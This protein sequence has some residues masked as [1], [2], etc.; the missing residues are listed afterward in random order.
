LVASFPSS[1]TFCIAS[2]RMELNP[3]ALFELMSSGLTGSGVSGP[4]LEIGEGIVY[5]NRSIDLWIMSLTADIADTLASYPRVAA[6]KSTMSSAG[7]IL[8]YAT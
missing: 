8:G 3:P 2:V 4:R 6:I 5:F 7:F 1:P